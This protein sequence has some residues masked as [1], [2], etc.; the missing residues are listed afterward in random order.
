MDILLI[1]INILTIHFT[2]FTKTKREGGGGEGRE[3]ER[4]RERE[5][6]G[7]RGGDPYSM[8]LSFGVQFLWNLAFTFVLNVQ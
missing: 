2:N 5:G 1:Q 6:A 8:F 3:R 4:E 7:E